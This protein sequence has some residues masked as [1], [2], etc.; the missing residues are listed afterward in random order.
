[1]RSYDTVRAM[2]PE[3]GF[4]VE[5]QSKAG[6]CE[7]KV[8]ADY[9]VPAVIAESLDGEETTCDHCGYSLKLKL[10]EMYKHV[11]MQVLFRGPEDD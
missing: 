9:E 4:F 2:C 10:P 8:F 5:F 1:M 7:F 6:P 3:C 11:E